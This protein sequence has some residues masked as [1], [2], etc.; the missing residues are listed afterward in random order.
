LIST[1]KFSSCC[2]NVSS[3]EVLISAPGV[4]STPPIW[5][6]IVR[7]QLARTK[8]VFW[9]SSWCVLPLCIPVS[10]SAPCSVDCPLFSISVW[11]CH[12][13]AQDLVYRAEIFLAPDFSHYCQDSVEYLFVCRQ[14]FLPRDSLVQVVTDSLV[15]SHI[16]FLVLC[17]GFS[18]GIFLHLVF[19]LVS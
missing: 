19:C 6:S 7:F 16:V 14:R 18:F 11:F 12:P 8:S 5:I 2:P 3:L 17:K 10:S 9:K 1:S 4:L 13:R 15:G